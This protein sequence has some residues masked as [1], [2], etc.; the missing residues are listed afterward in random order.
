MVTTAS[1]ST[2]AHDSDKRR[3]HSIERAK[4][5]HLTRQLQLRLQYAKLKVE[6]GWQRQNLNEVENL[7]FHHSRG[8]KSQPTSSTAK[9]SD[10]NA[11]PRAMGVPTTSPDI[12]S[13]NS[14][15]D[16]HLPGLRGTIQ[17][18]CHLHPRCDAGDSIMQLDVP[19]RPPV[20]GTS[21]TTSAIV[22]QN[23]NPN[24]SNNNL[25][26]LFTNPVKW[27][28][29]GTLHHPSH[30]APQ[31]PTSSSQPVSN[32]SFKLHPSSSSATSNTS[33]TALTYDSF[34][35]NHNT[36]RPF[37]SSFINLLSTSDSEANKITAQALLSGL[38]AKNISS[39]LSNVG[40]SSDLISG[41]PS[42]P[43]DVTPTPT[44]A[45]RR[46]LPLSTAV[47]DGL[48]DR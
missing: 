32:T 22:Q 47:V 28:E 4:V 21:T 45:I 36:A 6:H 15:Q 1:S 44:P 16:A 40:L 19:S 12:E 48:K 34:W 13:A 42:P 39:Y 27:S 43:S 30:P 26:S 9:V 17:N 37:R 23:P 11:E 46:T 2:Q 33:S 41:T 10:V 24:V 20:D 8:L 5:I 14:S 7:Y 31:A 35:S 29:K 18:L 38:S 3:K 25:S